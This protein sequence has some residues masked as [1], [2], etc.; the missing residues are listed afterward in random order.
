MIQPLD[1]NGTPARTQVATV[2][3]CVVGI[4]VGG[5]RKGF[6][7][8]AL[9]PVGRCERFA[10]AE[11][12]AVVDWCRAHGAQVIAIDAPCRWSLNGRSRLAE[13]ALA[14]VGIHAFATPSAAV[15]LQH[16]FYRWMLNGAALYAAIE[17]GWPLFDGGAVAARP[18]CCE[19]LPHAVACALAG[20]VIPARRKPG[21]RRALIEAAGIASRGLTGMDDIDAAL[22]ALAARALANGCFQAYGDPVEGF[23]IVPEGLAVSRPAEIVCPRP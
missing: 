18:V 13:R 15:A 9:D 11:V 23:I 7:A 4:D 3:A 5:R 14:A 19:T 22:C 21:L 20:R 1:P 10:S 8:V 6:H 16:P 2:D 12:A 17:P